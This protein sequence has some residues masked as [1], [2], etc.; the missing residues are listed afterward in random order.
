M[1]DN[2]T[3][4][5]A[6]A[7]GVKQP[8]IDALQANLASLSV[9]SPVNQNGSYEFDRVLKAGPVLKRTRKTKVGVPSTS[10]ELSN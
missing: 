4:T 1:A 9:G 8:R 5:P 7:S 10:C 2:V 6:P 3:Q